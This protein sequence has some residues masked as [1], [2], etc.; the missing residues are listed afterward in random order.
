MLFSWILMTTQL[1][2]QTFSALSEDP[3]RVMTVRVTIHKQ[4][5]RDPVCVPHV[6]MAI[7][8][9][10]GTNMMRGVKTFSEYRESLNDNDN[11]LP[12][13]VSECT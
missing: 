5:A 11:D 9:N 3:C 8:T 12:I 6:M 10:D 2:F 13:L 1:T 4:R 7:M